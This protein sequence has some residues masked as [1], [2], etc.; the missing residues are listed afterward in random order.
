MFN[1]S[2][3]FQV[4]FN[5]TTLKVFLSFAL[6][7]A[8]SKQYAQISHGTLEDVV[9][10]GESVEWEV[11]SNAAGTLVIDQLPTGYFFDGLVSSDCGA[12]LT[13]SNPPTFTVPAACSIIYSVHAECEAFIVRDENQ[14]G[15]PN[16]NFSVSY[17]WNG[18]ALPTIDITAETNA[19]ELKLEMINN[20]SPASPYT[21]FMRRVRV[22]ND[23]LDSYIDYPLEVCFD[24]GADLLLNNVFLDDGASGIPLVISGTNCVSVSPAQ[25][26]FALD[27]NNAAAGMDP[28]RLEG[29]SSTAGG[30]AECL[31]FDLEL[32]LN[33]CDQNGD[34]VQDISTNWGCNG[35]SCALDT[36]LS[37]NANISF[38]V[39]NLSISGDLEPGDGCNNEHLLTEIITITNSGNGGADNVVIHIK[40]K[41]NYNAPMAF[42]VSNIELDDVRS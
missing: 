5:A 42:D 1:I 19:P 40:P 16:L 25:F 18:T 32:V 29:S 22:C 3:K 6:L 35:Q 13:S 8:A 14:G 23:G 36:E 20:G 4:A 30:N 37:A 11:I 39:P 10:C 12:T 41:W 27:R 31:F 26:Q 28:S 2:G 21:S 17:S 15:D 7:F 9:V 34:F 33:S 38:D 24:N